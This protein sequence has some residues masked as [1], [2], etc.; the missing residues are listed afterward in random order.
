[1]VLSN[2]KPNESLEYGGG[3]SVIQE[4]REKETQA[5]TSYIGAQ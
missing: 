4:S 1:M 2:K 3:I 5:Q